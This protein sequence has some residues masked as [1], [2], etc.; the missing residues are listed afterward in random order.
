MQGGRVHQV[1]TP[2]EVYAH[3]ATLFVAAFVGAMNVIADLPIGAGGALSFGTETRVASALAGRDRITL[4][5]RLEDM[6][7]VAP[8]QAAPGDALALDGTVDKVS[9]AGRE[10]F[11][12]VRLDTGTQIQAHMHRPDRELM[13]RAGA[14]LRLILPL[15]RLH[16]FDPATG[17]RVEAAS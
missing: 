3:P 11:Y 1:G 16:L 10:A 2:W 9:F 8:D 7:L 15:A 4:A 13:D 14:R 12:R 6:T 17:R 5:I